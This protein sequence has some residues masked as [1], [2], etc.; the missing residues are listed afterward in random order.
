MNGNDLEG[1]QEQIR[2]VKKRAEGHG[3][4]GKVKFAVNAFVIA[5]ETEAEAIRVLQEIQGK[6]DH[7]AVEA[8]RVQVQNAGASTSNKTGRLA[9]IPL[10]GEIVS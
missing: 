8:F 2:D 10:T 3:R 7:D 9:R 5:R 4:A 1:F 6:A